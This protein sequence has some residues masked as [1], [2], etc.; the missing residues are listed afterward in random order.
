[1]QVKGWSEDKMSYELTNDLSIRRAEPEEWGV[2]CSVYYNMRYNG[3]F[4]E[5]S[6][7]NPRSNAFWIYKGDS[8]IGGVRMSPNVIYHL[9]VIPPFSDSFGVLKLLKGLLIHWSDRKEPIRT[10][11]VLPDQV[12]LYA[13][14]GF[15][16]DEFRCR[17][18]QR[19]TE[20]FQ[21]D[22]EDNL[23][24]ESPEVRRMRQGINGSSLQK[25]LPAVIGRAL[26]AA[27]M[28]PGGS[29]PLWE[30]S[31]LLILITLMK[32]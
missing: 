8:K 12:Q 31:C 22:W 13:R 17:W 25:R 29:K 11:E 1:M 26:E 24:I 14:A 2:Y 3:F 16:P 18:M 23:R 4:R 6:Y 5:E 15:W 20:V 30:I 21:V 19:P 27:W 9:F 10:Y 32:Y 28:R 7:A